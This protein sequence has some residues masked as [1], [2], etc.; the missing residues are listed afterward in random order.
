MKENL[1]SSERKILT[2]DQ[3][4]VTTTTAKEPDFPL[5]YKI[6]YIIIVFSHGIEFTYYIMNPFHHLISICN[7]M[8][9]KGQLC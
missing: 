5:I 1:R 3:G 2:V 4:F 7:E 6:S 8:Y 9:S